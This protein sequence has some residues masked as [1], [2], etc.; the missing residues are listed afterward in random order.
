MTAGAK[1]RGNEIWGGRYFVV[2]V[3]GAWGRK[4]RGSTEKK[5]LVCLS[6]FVEGISRWGP[7]FVFVSEGCGQMRVE[8]ASRKLRAER[9]PRTPQETHKSC[10]E[11]LPFVPKPPTAALLSSSSL[12]L[13]QEAVRVDGNRVRC[14]LLHLE[15]FYKLVSFNAPIFCKNLLLPNEWTSQKWDPLLV[16]LAS[17][18]RK[19][20][21]THAICSV[22][23]LMWSHKGNSQISENTQVFVPDPEATVTCF[24][25]LFQTWGRSDKH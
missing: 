18:F 15:I 2:C 19:Y 22:T 16:F 14:H 12:G 20:V 4:G 25:F 24:F 3:G 10:K 11:K 5:K 23:R 8:W 13:H 9:R 1:M 17:L 7:V 6:Q 21:L